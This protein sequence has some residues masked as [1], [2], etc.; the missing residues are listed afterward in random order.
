MS[1]QTVPP[2]LS[3]ATREDFPAE[4]VGIYDHIV[5]TRKL[6]YMPVMFAM[7]GHSP[8]A[9]ESVASVGEHVRFHSVMDPDLRELVICTVSQVVGNRFEWCHHIHRLPD[10]LR[11]KVGTPAIE[12]EPAPIGPA[13]RFCR[14]AANGEIVDDALI[15]EIKSSLGD[16]GLVDLTV[17]VGYYQLLGTFCNQ[18]GVPLDPDIEDVPFNG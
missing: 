11:R 1:N 14:L 17:M 2:R 16:Q 7:M 15:A 9:L 5:E 13:M 3:P 18:L 10:D 8:S 4:Q 12:D 6:S